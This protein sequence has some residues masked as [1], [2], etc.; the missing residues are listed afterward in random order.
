MYFSISY[1]A[2]R[3]SLSVVTFILTLLTLLAGYKNV[4]LSGY[5]LVSLD[6]T[7]Y[8]TQYNNNTQQVLSLHDIYTV[9]LTRYCAGD[10]GNLKVS[11]AM[12]STGIA[13]CSGSNIRGRR[14]PTHS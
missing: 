5:P 2:L 10:S 8:K 13:V 6:F 3:W 14:L 4:F 1:H 9:Y 12:G 7:H 11:A